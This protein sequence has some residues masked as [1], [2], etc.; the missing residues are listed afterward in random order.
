M[1]NAQTAFSTYAQENGAQRLVDSCS[2]N[3]VNLRAAL[4]IASVCIDIR[5]SLD[6]IN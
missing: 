1:Y 2:A 5:L 6:R 4:R 3:K